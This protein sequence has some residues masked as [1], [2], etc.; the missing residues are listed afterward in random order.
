MID[1]PLDIIDTESLD[2]EDAERTLLALQHKPLRIEATRYFKNL[3]RS[4]R[5]RDVKWYLLATF[6]ALYA[7]EQI[8]IL[9]PEPS[10]WRALVFL[11][12][13]FGVAI[14]FWM[15]ESYFRARAGNPLRL[16]EASASKQQ[17]HDIERGSVVK[18]V[19]DVLTQSM[20]DAGVVPSSVSDQTVIQSLFKMPT[21]S[22]DRTIATSTLTTKCLSDAARVSRNPAWGPLPSWSQQ[23]HSGYRIAGRIGS[24]ISPSSQKPL[25]PGIR[26]QLAKV[27]NVMHEL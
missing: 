21:D 8:S 18:K 20:R 2:H 16:H 9:L 22:E 27:P 4:S 7:V 15:L 24:G 1:S 26:A 3:A 12:V 19:E 6:L 5:V 23:P 17:Q 14:L 13:G 11:I 10:E 25:K